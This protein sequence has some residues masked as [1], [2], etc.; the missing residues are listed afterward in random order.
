MSTEVGMRLKQTQEDFNAA[1]AAQ[2]KAIQAMINDAKRQLRNRNKRLRKFR[3]G[4]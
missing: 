1:V 2:D 3:R 4:K